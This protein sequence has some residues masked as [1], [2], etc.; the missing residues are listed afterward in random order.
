MIDEKLIYPIPKKQ[1]LYLL[2][3]KQ[4]LT[5]V[6]TNGYHFTPRLQIPLQA[7]KVCRLSISCRINNDQLLTG[8][9][10]TILFY[11]TAFYSGWL[12]AQILSILPL[13][14]GIYLFYGKRR[15]FLVVYIR[16]Q[17]E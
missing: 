13:L 8:F 3:H 14:Y 11:C 15:Q 4:A 9:L 6:A 10:T 5:L 17:D 1:P 7:G 12:L 16:Q 2:Y